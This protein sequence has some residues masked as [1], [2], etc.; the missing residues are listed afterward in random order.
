MF[1]DSSFHL[2]LSTQ[3]LTKG[4]THLFKKEAKM[5][6][7]FSLAVAVAAISLASCGGR[8]AQ[9]AEPDSL[10]CK[11]GS[12][13]EC[14]CPECSCPEGA[15]AEGKCE[16]CKCTQDCCNKEAVQ[17]A[18]NE[19][20]ALLGEQLKNANPEQI[21]SI[22]NTVAEKVAQFLAAGDTES[23]EKYTALISNFVAENAD[24]LKEIGASESVAQA[25]A[26]V[27]GIPS[28]IVETAT[29]AV[30]GVKSAALTSALNAIA[31]GE[32]VVDAVKAAATEVAA[33]GSQAAADAQVSA[34]AVKAA[35]EAAPE[36]VKEAAKAK[37]NEAAESA[38]QQATDAANKAIDDAA[39]AA[40]KK[41][42][43]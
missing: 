13:V 21:K 2:H 8:T 5:K 17:G 4:C 23:A 10:C 27:E 16:N 35:V 29:Q 36:A 26:K 34:E 41:L 6:K 37:A 24:K 28:D 42:G 43:L 19:V 3:S 22:A 39:A 25:L 30:T 14:A 32:S 12:C 18:A 15:C 31:K 1:I 7:L 11:S 38:K 9:T 40:K 33:E 20:V